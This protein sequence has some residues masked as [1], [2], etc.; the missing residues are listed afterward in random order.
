[1]ETALSAGK[2]R[3][4]SHERPRGRRKTGTRHTVKTGE[5]KGGTG[6]R[7]Q[8]PRSPHIQERTPLLRKTLN[9]KKLL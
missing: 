4:P 9:A 2:S 5:R 7:K 8:P 6:E 3:Q 1:M